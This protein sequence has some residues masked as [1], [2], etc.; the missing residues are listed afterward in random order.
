MRFPFLVLMAAVGAAGVSLEI[1]Q[2]GQVQGGVQYDLPD[3]MN[4]GD[5][6]LTP[7]DFGSLLQTATQIAELPKNDSHVAFNVAVVAYSSLGIPV[8]SDAVV[9]VS[10]KLN[11]NVAS[12]LT[13]FT[14][15]FSG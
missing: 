12:L 13:S 10:S 3:F 4:T 11:R 1:R 14:F 8:A 6:A 7:A 2:N 9:G 5:G 15:Y